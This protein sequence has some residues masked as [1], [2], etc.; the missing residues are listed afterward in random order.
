MNSSP[1]TTNWWKTV[2]QISGLKANDASV[3]PLMVNNNLIFDEIEKANEFNRFFSSQS[4]IDDSSAMLPEELKTISDDIGYIELTVTEVEDILKIVNPTKA[5]GPDLISPKLLKEA[6]SVLKYPLYIATSAKV[7]R[8]MENSK[9]EVVVITNVE[10]AVLP[11]LEDEDV[12]TNKSP[13][14]TSKALTSTSQTQTQWNQRYEKFLLDTYKTFEESKKPIKN[15]WG[16][17][18]DLV[19]K[20]LDVKFTGEQCRLKIKCLKEKFYRHQKKLNKSGE[21]TEMPP[22]LEIFESQPDVKPVITMD[23][24]V[25]KESDNMDNDIDVSSEE[26]EDRS[27]KPDPKKAKLCPT[28]NEKVKSKRKTNVEE[29][30]DFF[31]SQT[32]QQQEANERRHR[33]RCELITSL[34]GVIKDLAKK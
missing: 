4:N 33:E 29:M 5:S 14:S 15:K 21:H 26:E 1:S 8:I 2:K 17:I 23:L 22:E 27:I 12:H 25:I 3:P 7:V 31:E 10:Q 19:N 6:S 11:M 24:N 9:E 16:A 18:A 28:P 30:K 34:V 32:N 13:T 20:E